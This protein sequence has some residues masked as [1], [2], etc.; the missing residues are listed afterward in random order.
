MERDSLSWQENPFEGSALHHIETVGSTNDEAARLA[1]DGAPAGTMVLADR[2]TEGRGRL[3]RKWQSTPGNMHASIILR[4]TCSFAAASQISLLAAVA[5]GDMLLEHG[6]DDLDLKL[7]WPNDVLIGGAKIA[8]ILLECASDR[9][10]GVDHVILG[11]GVNVAWSPSDAAYPVTSLEAAGF[12]RHQPKTWLN[13]YGCTLR[14]WL[15]RWRRDGFAGVREAWRAR[16]Y[17]LGDPIR[18]RLD[19]EEVDGRFVDLSESGALL[20]ERADGSRFEATAGD[21]VYADR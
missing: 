20:I 1:L 11:V 4:P 18:L 6:P 9:A 5:L 8:G 12:A 7:K 17:G 14:I 19:R 13:A 15:D 10:G 21:V 16:G 2:Q 3:G